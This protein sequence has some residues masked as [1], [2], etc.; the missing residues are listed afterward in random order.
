MVLSRIKSS[1]LKVLLS[2]EKT[3]NFIKCPKIETFYTECKLFK[4]RDASSTI[5]S[6]LVIILLPKMINITL[7][8]VLLLNSNLKN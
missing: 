6:I 8:Q 7:S 4:L 3:L 1:C 2:L 5:T